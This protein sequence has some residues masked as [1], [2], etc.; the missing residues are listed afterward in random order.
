MT[1]LSER[2]VEAATTITT[3]VV[4]VADDAE[5][6]S[7]ND[8]GANSTG[9]SSSN[10]DSNDPIRI[11]FM[12][13]SIV[14]FFM[15]QISIDDD[16]DRDEILGLYNNTWELNTQYTQTQK[17]LKSSSQQSGS[18][19]V[20]MM[21]PIN[22]NHAGSS[23]AF[24]TAGA[25]NHWSLLVVLIY[26]EDLVEHNTTTSTSIPSPR[27]RRPNY[28]RY[29]HFDSCHGCNSSAAK[30]VA[31]RVERLLSIGVIDASRRSNNDTSANTSTVVGDGSM[32][33]SKESRELPKR[34]KTS[35]AVVDCV[36][37]Q[38]SNGYDCGLCTLANSEALS[39]GIDAMPRRHRRREDC[40][41]GSGAE[42]GDGNHKYTY[43]DD[44]K[45]V[46]KW[47]EQTVKS[48]MIGY[49]GMGKM[50]KSIRRKMAA[51]VR[52]MKGSNH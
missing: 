33:E 11:V 51:D 25:G 49:G 47:L 45:E 50:A 3:A 43:D 13:P 18:K 36:T 17:K 1:R 37:P 7:K 10:N 42:G 41:N 26:I 24:Q 8:N 20:A 22:D 34:M 6:A 19:M 38:Q 14:S 39:S 21:I 32:M 28:A 2:T 46:K 16:E 52:E 30:I 27:R 29:F 31:T 44:D 23:W 4:A 9:S 35:V 48:F 15:H 40:E 12:D 5:T